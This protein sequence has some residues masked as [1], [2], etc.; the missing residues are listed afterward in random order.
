MDAAKRFG[1][2]I[3]RVR[4]ARKLSQEGLAERAEIHRTQIS[5]IEGGR[6]EP[7]I[8]TLVRLAGA[9]EVDASALL[10]GIIWRPPG[11]GRPGE[12]AVADPPEL[13]RFEG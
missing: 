3:L 11:P 4:Q 1:E 2:N 8:F 7:R 12:F 6:R 9:L 10:E 5:L 13:P